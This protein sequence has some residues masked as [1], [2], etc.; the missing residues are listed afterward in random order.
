[1]DLKGAVA[2]VTGASSGIGLAVAEEL[3]REGVAVV[4]GARRVDRLEEAVAR[5]RAA[6]GRAESMTMDVTREAD[7]AALV[8]RA[9]Q[10]FGRLDIM[11]C[12]AGFGYYGSVEEMDP[13]VMRRM[14]DV[15][16][17]GTF[18]GTRAALPGVPAAG[19]RP[20]DVRVVDRR[21][22]RHPAD[23]RLQRHQGGT[24]DVRRIAPI[25]MC[26]DRRPR[27]RGVPGLD[28]HGVPRGHGA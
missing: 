8:T 28:D 4:L 22:A 9:Q 27:E 23:E 24:S 3:A 19:T 15:N 26:R 2:V 14:M 5:I 13:D 20:S 16:F 18:Y 6:G 25:R 17:M 1:M 7:V 10:A 11:I 12:N 21:Q